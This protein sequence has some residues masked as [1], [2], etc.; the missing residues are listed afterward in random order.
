MIWKIHLRNEGMRMAKKI[1]G[2]KEFFGEWYIL[3]QKYG[4]PPDIHN[5]S[6]EAVHFWNCLCDDVR[7]LNN[8]YRTHQLQPFFRELC[9]DLIGEVRRRSKAITKE[10]MG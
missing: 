10:R 2:E 9:L 7:N 3:L 1:E 6:K 4:F 8:K 5:E